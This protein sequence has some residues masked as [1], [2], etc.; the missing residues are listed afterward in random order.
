MTIE[1]A[2]DRVKKCEACKGI[3]ANTCPSTMCWVARQ[4]IFG[5]NAALEKAAEICR[6]SEFD[7]CAGFYEEKILKLKQGE[8]WK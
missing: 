3:L 7:S 8:E 6:K 5:W 1:E 4:Y 2:V